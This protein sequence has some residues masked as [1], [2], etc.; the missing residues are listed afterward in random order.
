M[1]N[2]QRAQFRLEKL[3]VLV[4]HEEKVKNRKPERINR[5]LE[6]AM[7]RRAFRQTKLVDSFS[8]KILTGRK[9]GKI[10]YPIE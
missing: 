9:R 10:N 6:M 4:Y 3:L 1:K 7:F 5:T 2:P 8:G